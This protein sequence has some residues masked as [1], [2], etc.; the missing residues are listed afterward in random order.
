MSKLCQPLV[1]IQDITTNHGVVTTC[2]LAHA[3]VR[4]FLVKR[5]QNPEAQDDTTLRV[6]PD[7]L[8]SI[9]LKYLMQS[10]FA[11]LLRK[12]GETFKD[13]LEEDIVNHHLLSYAAKYWDKHLDVVQ[14]W[15]S[16]CEVVKRFTMSG[17]FFT[18][19][20][21]QSLLVGG[22]SDYKMW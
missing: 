3:T 14:E 9:C 8:A 11:G 1:R 22:M 13:E 20:Q 21:V 17:Q 12:D 7:T 18:T 19:L 4:K 16:L 5:A 6:V 2:T 10:R 15:E